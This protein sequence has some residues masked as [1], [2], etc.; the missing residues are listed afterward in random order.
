MVVVAC[1]VHRARVVALN[2]SFSPPETLSI[3]EVFDQVCLGQVE[4]LLSVSNNQLPKTFTDKETAQMGK[5]PL[6][7]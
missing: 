7:W 3:Q 6:H 4:N 1:V 5:T 2:F